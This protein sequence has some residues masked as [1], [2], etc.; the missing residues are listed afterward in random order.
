MVLQ[1]LLSNEQSLKIWHTAKEGDSKV[2]NENEEC[3]ENQKLVQANKA[4]T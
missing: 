1:P 4:M 2:K 3:L